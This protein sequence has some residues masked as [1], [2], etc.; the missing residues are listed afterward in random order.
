VVAGT[1]RA[2]L[3]D[4][5]RRRGEHTTQ[6]RATEDLIE[7]R[8]GVHDSNHFEVKLDY[9]LD[10]TRAS[11]QYKV[12]CYLFVPRSLGINRHSYP[13]EQF[14]SDVQGY[15]RFKTP[16]IGLRTLADA[17]DPLSP[18]GI[19]DSSIDSL[20]Q[21]P[22][23]LELRR[24]LSHELRMFGCIAR[25]QLRDRTAALRERIRGL[26]EQPGAAL[27]QLRSQVDRFVADLR[28]LLDAWRER[29]AE[30]IPAGAA[31]RLEPSTS[32]ASKLD[33]RFIPGELPAEVA[34]TYACT[35]E[36]LS[37]ALEHKL[38]S[39]V[40]ELDDRPVLAELR[41]QLC[42]TLL[43]ERRYRERSGYPGV[44]VDDAEAY[45][46]RRGMLKKLVNSV[47]WLETSKQKEG[48]GIGNLAAAIA[49]GAA[50]A[51]ALIAAVLGARAG[52]HW[53]V[54]DTWGFVVAGTITYMFKDRIKDWLRGFFSSQ[55]GRW[56]ADYATDI[57]DPVSRREIGRCRESFSY[58]EFDAVPYEV[59]ALRH[60]QAKSEVEIEAKPE[61]V[62]KYEKDV[63]LS[64]ASLIERLHL[65]DYEINDIMRFCV[66]QFL[67]RADDPI[68]R[69]PVYDPELDTVTRKTFQKTYHLNLVMVMRSA[70]CLAVLQRIRVV[71]DKHGIRRLEPV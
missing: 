34:E 47:L 66:T 15:I 53:F 30:L 55:T 44:D 37:Q 50:M 41:A 49:A 52:S 40:A 23:E 65:A 64:S 59:R 11:S 21:N 14:Y 10:S 38:S 60:G 2:I 6:A 26:P 24:R 28:V 33:L 19:I 20:R 63:H 54:A 51:F 5:R 13:R 22:H 27:E 18:L 29:R 3:F 1:S 25:A 9:C 69:L 16:V 57:R 39:L 7:S 61:I 17:D 68:V 12:E 67:L 4:A 35:D 48:R 36:Y 31:A 45:V 70:G 56:L 8:I 32:G 46:F 58:L 43:A 71:F 62:I 42:A